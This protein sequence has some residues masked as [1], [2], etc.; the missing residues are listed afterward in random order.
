MPSLVPTLP[1]DDR[2]NGWS[3]LLP[4]RLAN[5]PLRGERSFD[6]LVIGGGYTGLA[7]ARRIAQHRPQDSIALLDAG[8]VGDNA[9][10]RNSGFAIDLPHNFASADDVNLARRAIGVSRYAIA[11]LEQL[12]AEHGIQ[13]DWSHAGKYHVAV[14]EDVRKKELD[15]YMRDLDAWGEPYEFVLRHELARRLG[16]EHYCAAVY[17]PGPRLMNPAA[18][19]RGLV[20]T[21]PSNVAVFEG[22]A[23]VRFDFEGPRPFAETEEGTVHFGKAILAVNAFASQFGVFRNQMIPIV[24]FASLTRPLSDAQLASLGSEREWGITPAH[25]VA[26][27]TMRL[28]RDRRLLIRHGFEYSPGFRCSDERR[29]AARAEHARLLSKRFPQLGDIEIDHFWMGWL[30]VSQNHA[31]A[32]GNVNPNV[33]AASCC[34][35]VGIVRNSAAGMLIADLACGVENDLIQDFTAQGLANRLPPRPILDLGVE[36]KLWWDVTAGRAES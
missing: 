16:T 1:D 26:G 30:S 13:C 31:P 14:T 2:T 22:S 32:F 23:V 17:T 6:W 36:A 24:L 28:T 19:C 33:Y 15:T 25:S 10:G 7:A 8:E 11:Q 18:L 34:N 5:F 9:S 35:G 12:I 3:R 21:L 4:D 20:D 29:Q 27:S